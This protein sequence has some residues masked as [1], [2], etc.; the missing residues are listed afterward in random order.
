MTIAKHIAAALLAG[1]AFAAPA[2]HAQDAAAFPNKPIRL[3][4]PYTPGGSADVLGRALAQQLAGRWG[5]PVVVDNKPGADGLL[6]ADAVAKAPADGYTLLY[7]P[8]ALY[9]IFPYM[10]PK[11]SVSAQ[12]DLDAVAGVSI[13]PMVM[14]VSSTLKVGSVAE[15]IA[16][17]KA[18]PGE[19]GFGSAG[20]SSLQRMIG[21]NFAR[22]AG[23]KMVHVPYKGTA[24]A[25]TDLAGGQ[26]HVL[27]GSLTSIEPL[28]KAGKARLL[29]VSSQ[30]RFALMPD[31]P[32]LGETLPGWKDLNTFQGIYAP[33][34]LPPAVARKI[35]E[36]V[37]AAAESPDMQA[38]LKANGF[39]SNA[40]TPEQFQ[41][42]LQTDYQT[43]GEVVRA[44]HIRPEK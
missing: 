19:I 29:A 14:A 16:L 4:V 44:A 12:R 22:L 24:Q 1:C 42:Q 6:G 11:A 38:R 18:R 36:A 26:L 27:Y 34:G 28:L 17:G 3:V 2:V 8:N 7:G 43:M 23:V 41:A 9:S 37:Q 39:Q 25:G 5:Q 13:A 33:K 20:N 31:T 32:A 30:K 21:E 40:G 15:L 10:H 35:A